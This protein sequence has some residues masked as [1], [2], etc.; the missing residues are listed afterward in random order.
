MRSSQR[1]SSRRRAAFSM[2]LVGEGG[3]PP[4]RQPGGDRR[5][6]RVDPGYHRR[7]A[8]GEIPE[9]GEDIYG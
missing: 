3:S 9:V 8:G 1:L 5:R 6:H 4:L 7:A 2:D